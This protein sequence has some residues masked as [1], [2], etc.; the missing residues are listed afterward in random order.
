[1]KVDKGSA[2]IEFV[3]GITLLFVVVSLGFSL[4]SV[5][6]QYQ[7]LDY[8]AKEML[9]EA[10]LAGNTGTNVTNRYD[11]IQKVAGL[12]PKSISFDGTKYIGG[13]KNVQINDRIQVTVKSDYTLFSS[14][15]GGGFT[16]ELVATTSGRSGVY[17]K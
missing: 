15:V 11:D 10:E 8:I 2:V 9:R 12:E 3:V 5:F 14:F 16:V 7:N 17:Y 4:F 1:M 6:P 13:T